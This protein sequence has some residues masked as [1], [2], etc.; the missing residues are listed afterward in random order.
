[1]KTLVFVQCKTFWREAGLKKINMAIIVNIDTS[2]EQAS[3]CISNGAHIL[4]QLSNDTPKN[5]AAFVQQAIH[6]LLI[7][8]HY[9]FEQIDAFAVVNGPGSYTGL[10][11]GLASAKG[12]CYA[13]NKPLILINTL[14]VMAQSGIANTQ[15]CQQYWYCPMIDAR[16]MEVFYGLYTHQLAEIIA[17]SAAIVDDLFLNTPLATQK[18]VFMGSGSHKWQQMNTSNQAIFS[19]STSSLNQIV[20]LTYNKYLQKEFSSVAYSQPFYIKEAF[21]ATKK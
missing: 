11:V 9:T 6:Q 19:K 5:H 18:I 13:L 16:R 3:V 15:N 4:A 21:V 8:T 17:P 1:M 2:Q 20:E 14:E 10:R 7:N 12:L